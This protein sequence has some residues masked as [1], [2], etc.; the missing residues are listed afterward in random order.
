[1]QDLHFDH[2]I[3]HALGGSNEPEN[4]Q[5]LCVDCNLSKGAR[6]NPQRA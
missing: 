6:I 4:I 1:M 3:P 2:I 5:I